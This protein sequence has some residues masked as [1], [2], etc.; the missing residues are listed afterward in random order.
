MAL[1]QQRREEEIE[2][3]ARETGRLIREADPK[4]QEELRDAASAILREEARGTEETRSGPQ[5]IRPMSPVAA[6]L[7]LLLIG[8]GLTFV[9]P[10]VGL[11]LVACGGLGVLWGVIAVWTRTEK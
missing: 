5:P 4:T 8:G 3:L 2:K 6:G 7:G 11:V 9:V 10:A 1:E